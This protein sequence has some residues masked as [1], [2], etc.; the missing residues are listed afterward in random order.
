MDSTSIDRPHGDPRFE[1]R[2]VSTAFTP[3]WDS[4]K[5]RG[6]QHN[7]NDETSPDMPVDF[8]KGR[9]TTRPPPLPIKFIADSLKNR[10]RY[11][12]TSASGASRQ[13]L[14]AYHLFFKVAWVKI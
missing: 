1:L 3:R 5:E 11:I 13:D 4:S 10:F 2:A 14:S 12:T 7:A 6:M 8:I 9:K